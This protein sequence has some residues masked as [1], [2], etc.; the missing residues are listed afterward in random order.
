MRAPRER[1]DPVQLGEAEVVADGQPELE[2]VGGLGEHDLVGRLGVL[3]LAV[4]DAADLDVEHVDLAVDG[5]DSPSGPTWTDVLAT[6]SW[7]SRRSAIEP[8]TRSMPSSR[9]S[10]ASPTRAGAPLRASRRRRRSPGPLP[11]R[12]RRSGSTTSSA[13]SAAAARVRRSA[14]ARLRSLSFVDWSCTAA[15]RN[16]SSSASPLREALTD[17]SIWSV[18]RAMAT[19]PIRGDGVRALDLPLPPG[20]MP[21]L[22]RR[23]PAQALALRG[24]LRAG[25]DAVRGRRPHRRGG[26]ALVGGRRC[27]TGG[28]SRARATPTRSSSTCD[29]GP[30]VEVVSPHGRSYI[31]T[32]KQAGMPVSASV[33][34]A[35][36]EWRRRRAGRF[37]RRVGRLSRAPHALALVGW[38]RPLA[39]RA[40]RSAWN[41]V[42]G[43][44]DAPRASERTVWVDGEPHEVEPRR[45]SPRTCPPWASCASPSGPPARTTP[46]D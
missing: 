5:L 22:R 40:R 6:R 39:R 25:A 28:C 31:W 38:H 46:T 2:P 26:A 23:S 35:G 18:L 33:R 16:R 29:E 4:L 12:S 42:D 45:R 8:A 7:P 14:A 13:P 43:V 9:A 21:A 17:Q 15:A 10:L 20:R 24:G 32:R 30:G 36:R 27:R 1:E 19:L 41:L 3:G 44:H 11:R 34:V 37:R